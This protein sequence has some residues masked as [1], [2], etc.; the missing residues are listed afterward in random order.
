MFNKGTTALP[1]EP[2][3]SINPENIKVNM[4]SN[5]I[6]YPYVTSTTN[7]QGVD[8]T[9]NEDGSVLV[10]GTNTSSTSYIWFQLTGDIS[11]KEDTPCFLSGCPEGGS[12]ST[13]KLRTASLEDT[14]NGALI[15]KTVPKTQVYIVIGM[16]ITVE[17]LVFKPMLNKGTTALPYEPYIAPKDVEKVVVAKSPNLIP[18]PYFTE[19]STR[20]G[21]DWTIN[22]DNSI[23]ANGTAT[24][25]SYFWCVSSLYFSKGTYT[26]S[27]C[28]EGGA[29]NTFWIGAMSLNSV[30]EYG[31]GVTTTAE[32][33]GKT[34]FYC[35]VK[36][37]VTVENIT[38]YPM[39]TKNNNP[40]IFPYPYQNSSMTQGGLTFTDNRDGTITVNGT[41]TK[42]M[43]FYYWNNRSPLKVNA[44]ENY[45]LTD[46][47]QAVGGQNIISKYFYIIH[48]VCQLLHSVIQV[49]GL[50]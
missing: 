40:N 4:S 9:V 10:N 34:N 28:P 11:F 15:N 29:T 37:G 46:V 23:T 47:L 35:I 7:I 39:L 19:S 31:E 50:I 27:G 42:A 41:S 26:V 25:D 3:K 17:N 30:K 36:Q 5:L 43:D 38:F 24:G 22:E 20:N 6:P 21:I 48:Q 14:G 18:Y 1:Y 12:F 8:F 49:L 33:E 16:G 44:G 45:L 32:E 13:Y 2:Y